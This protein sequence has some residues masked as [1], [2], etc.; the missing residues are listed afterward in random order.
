MTRVKCYFCPKDAAVVVRTKLG[1][2]IEKEHP[3]CKD[4]YKQMKGWDIVR[5]L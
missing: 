1:V 4:C 2:D 5:K 3:V